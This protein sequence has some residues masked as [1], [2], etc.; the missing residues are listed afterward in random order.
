MACPFSLAVFP[1]LQLGGH[2]TLLLENVILG[3]KFCFLDDFCLAVG[4][5]RGT[6][7]TFYEIVQC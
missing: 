7:T 6:A 3:G 2:V 5:R 1:N 4:M